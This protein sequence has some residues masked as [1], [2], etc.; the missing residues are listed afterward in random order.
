[1]KQRKSLELYPLTMCYFIKRTQKCTKLFFNHYFMYF[2]KRFF[3][4]LIA[5]FV[6]IG[7]YAK[8]RT[9][10]ETLT[11]YYS[12]R[13]G[14]G[15]YVCAA[16]GYAD[17]SGLLL[18]N[19][20][21][22]TT[23]E[24][25]WHILK[26]A[27]GTYRFVVAG[28]KKQGKVLGIKGSEADARARI[29]DASLAADGNGYETHFN[30]TLHI[31]S[32][33][34]SYIKIHDSDNNYWN[35]R[36]NYLALWNSPRATKN[37]TGSKFF[38]SEVELN[39]EFL[40]DEYKAYTSGQHPSGVSDFSLW[41]DQ[42]VA[43]TG[44]SDT[45]ME[46]ALPLGNGQIGTT[47]RGGVFKDE[48]QF[49]EKTLW[50]G[51]STNG[52]SMGQGYFQ[53][54]GSILV[55]DKSGAFSFTDGSKPVKEYARYL[56][57]MNGVAGVNFKSTDEQTSYSRRYFVS[58]TDSVFVAHYEAKGTDKLKL[59]F[60]YKPDAEIQASKVTYSHSMASFQ[61]SLQVV[62]YHTA[63]KVTASEGASITTT[64]KGV[65]VE[66]AT[67]ANLIM[68]AATNYDASKSGCV[69]GETAD[70]I[71]AKVTARIDAA[72]EK[73]YETLLSN[74]E[75]LFSSYMNRVDLKLGNRSG[76]TTEKLIQYYAKDAN[77]TTAEGLYLES[78]YFQYGRYL[79][80]AANLDADI[81]APSNLQGIW[82][83][84]SNTPF[85]HCDIHSD[86]NVEM[87]Y[88]PADPTN[89][90][91][92][93]LPFL[94]HIID[95]ATADNSPWK[96]LAQK[97][98]TGAKGWTVATE[99][100][101][102][103]GTSTWENKRLKTL[104]AWYCTHLWRH[105]KYT[106]DK[107]FLKKA[108]PVMY[109]AALFIKS[110]ATKDSHGK[111]EITNE[112]SP[113]HGNTDVTAFAQQIGYELL[114][115][116][117][118]AHQELGMESPLGTDQISAIQDLHDH[119]DKGLWTEKYNGKTCISEWKNNKLSDPGHRHLSHLMCLYPFSQV[120]AFDTT[121][122]GK[123]LFQAAYNGQIARNGDVTGWSMGWQM[124]TYARCLDGNKA[125]RNLSLALRHARSYIIKM[126]GYGGCYYN[127][128]DAHSPFQIDGNYGC[129]SGM[130]E[131]LLQSYDDVITLLPA[132]PSAWKNGHVKGLKAQGNYAVEIE[133]K[134][135]KA[136]MAK[137]TNGQDMDRKVKVRI[138]NV[139]NEYLIGSNATLSVDCS[140][141]S[142]NSHAVGGRQ[143]MNI[144]RTWKFHLGDMAGAEKADFNDNNWIDAHL[145]HSFSVPYFMYK[146][147]Y[148]GYGWYRKHLNVTPEMANK[149]VTIEFEGS[150]IQ[151]EV[152]INDNK[153]GSH[154]GGYT[155]F[156]FDLTPYLHEGDN[157]LAIRVNNLWNARV[158]PRAGDHQF[159]GGI[160]RDVWLNV[161]DRLHVDV[162][163]TFV[164]TP[165][166]NKQEADCK[167]ETEIVN[168]YS[169]S[170]QA[171]LTTKIVSPSGKIVA[172]KDTTVT[173]N[174]QS[175]AV[176]VQTLPS[177]KEPELWSP[178]VPN[179]Y[180]AITSLTENNQE[181]D[182]YITT[183]GIRSMEWT[184]DKG[185]FL[186]GEH[187]WL[188]GANVHQDQAGWGDAVTNK[189][190]ERDV[191]MI[192]DA[193][194][195]CIRGSHY[196]HD[197]AFAHA[198]DSIGIILFMENAFWG[199]GGNQ[200]EG[201]WG[202]GAPASA[203]PTVAADQPYFDQSV[204]QQLKESI[205]QHRNSPSIA[206]WSL[207]NEPFFCSSSVE[208]KMK[209]LLNAETD[210]ARLWDPTRQVAIGGC[211]RKNVDRLG[212][213][214]IA[215]YNGDGASR[216]EFQNPGVP[217]LVSEY[218]SPT[219][220]RPGKFTAAWGNVGNGMTN[221]PAWRSGHV[222]WCGFDHGTVGGIGLA[223]MG[224]IDYFRIPK[225]L[226]YW[227]KEAYKNNNPSP[228]A[229]EWPS[230]GTP[231]QLSLTASAT[232][233]YGTDGTDDAQLLVKV[234]DHTGQQ[235]SNSVPVTL[236]IV[237]GPG[238]FPTGRQITF[239]PT[240]TSV[241]ELPSNPA[242]DIRI[243]DGQAAIAFRSYYGGK[244]VIEATSP[245]LTPVQIEINTM[246]T[247][248]WQEGVD[249]PVSDRPYKRY[250]ASAEDNP[251]T[252]S[253]MTLAS[254]RPTMS[255]SDMEGTN[256]IN[257]NDG[258]ANTIWK[259][260]PTDN[261]RW[262]LVFLE[263]QYSVNRIELTFPTADRYCYV[264][265]VS[266]DGD[267]WSKVVDQSQ[268]T[269]TAQ[270]CMA[271]GNFGDDISYVKVTFTSHL[272]GLAEVRVGG[273][274]QKGLIKDDVL[275]G[276]IIGTSGAWNNNE[277]NMKE[278]AM[279]FDGDTFFDGPSG[280]SPF[281][282]GL[283]LGYNMEAR[284]QGVSYMPRYNSNSSNYAERMIGGKFQIANKA[285]FSDAKDVFV[286]DTKPT[287][288]VYNTGESS[289][290]N[291]K[292]RY[293]RYL[294]TDAGN[295]NVAE[296]LFRGVRDLSTGINET[297]ASI[298]FDSDKLYDVQGMKTSKYTK[299]IKISK[300]KKFLQR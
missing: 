220:D 154:T 204:L 165:K 77:K 208:A 127:L 226:Y 184:S 162:N 292:V 193:G 107:A 181:K 74:H 61:G 36:G 17:N 156:S 169:S 133:W 241:K 31:G 75:K 132:L 142:D 93:H 189:A 213:G 275:S 295:G 109:D 209:N 297:T 139:I 71:A 274:G 102:F 173:V 65:L 202:E 45:W 18:T 269:L 291:T 235:I 40:Y 100:N 80:I 248:E 16:P 48:I 217:N 96:A 194:F 256:K 210:S 79:T 285:D 221:R 240:T 225:R 94:R 177:V 66:N 124:N 164:M 159:S 86:I 267:N 242:E 85:W 264:I 229:P 268:T 111:Y 271:V 180:K 22:P 276:T 41:Y 161:T 160:Y 157:V 145:P 118:K 57:I 216:P 60:A 219:Y 5:L 197:P 252:K 260:S 237:S 113:E 244:T 105:Y 290:T 37:D 152:Y 172:Q 201:A 289:D 134:D 51:Y 138:R 121:D 212:K 236:R 249:V 176:F 273:S 183:F 95:L 223:K 283:D 279:D 92:M 21:R 70:A 68:A 188:Q 155:T 166:V 146:D 287:Y 35:K 135:G 266:K 101:I 195:N 278:A 108:L 211:Q 63:F 175:H 67:W 90:S 126:S 76:K 98:K 52:S 46:Y 171:T 265:E 137:I 174:P 73:S 272:A 104:G 158:A 214:A 163:G 55:T 136:T 26:N 205:R 192:K 215:F 129:T 294:S 116:V 258:D 8:D 245:G 82:N 125:R 12:I 6:F 28:G 103:G 141:F 257:V 298:P 89:L 130:A 23:A 43:A 112:W 238:E 117:L 27:D 253:V 167:V 270:K 262:W 115:E 191:Q 190:I 222:I 20:K 53:N 299:G 38:I 179:L 203:Y 186:N 25:L 234:C 54:F 11:K 151:T 140:A 288:K 24:G 97:I 49:N 282:V 10:T 87:N 39:D 91:E 50:S 200:D 14:H 59:N 228:Q 29:I 149:N 9:P 143:R 239:T 131:M 144:N 62:K 147:V 232:T 254:D 231:A 84:R 281:W 207:C 255:S 30:G 293:V 42:P 7:A 120:S 110:V 19:A 284:L 4:G 153:V 259:P 2:M 69:S 286:I 33:L 81:H 148:H 227:Y 178:E 198:C 47:I 13:N 206:A 64:D 185:F 88:W 280:G 247:P 230:S 243:Q 296:L 15:G 250:V 300:S 170:K 58:S 83:D 233:L 119:F 3:W 106:L 122:E 34:P 224:I 168:N 32:D 277:K 182:C 114:D 196:P 99:N 199:M 44:S 1:M 246:G 56:D 251:Q 72:T 187:Y 128:F 123:K 263:G 218:G 78:L 150:F 261:K